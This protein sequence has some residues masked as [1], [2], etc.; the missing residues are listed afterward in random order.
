MNRIAFRLIFAVAAALGVITPVAAYVL[1][2]GPYWPD[3]TVTLHLKLGDSPTYTDSSTP[4]STAAEAAKTW[5]PYIGRVQLATTVDGTGAGGSKNGTNEVFFSTSAYGQ[6]F[7]TDVLAVTLIWSSSTRRTE[8]D[9]IVNASERWDSYRGSLQYSATDLRRVLVH[10]F[11]HVLGLDHP[12]QAGQSVYSIMNA[13]IGNIETPT[14]DDQ[15]GVASIYGYG[16]GNQPTPPHISANTPVDQSIYLGQPVT[17]SVSLGSSDTPPFTYQW[18][19]NDVAIIGAT[20]DSY[21][22][23]QVQAS[24]AGTYSVVVSNT[25]GS[26]TSREA[27]LTVS[28]APPPSEGT[29]TAYGTQLSLYVP[30][31]SLTPTYGYQWYRDGQAIA[32]ATSTYYNV[33]PNWANTPADYLAVVTNSRGSVA[34]QAYS[35]VPTL[36]RN[37]VATSSWIAVER[38]GDL[39]YFLC[40]SPARIERYDIAQDKWL[41]PISLGSTPTAFRTDEAGLFV[42][43]GSSVMR[44]DEAGVVGTTLLSGLPNNVKE[45]FVASGILYVF[46]PNEAT[47]SQFKSVRLSDGLVVDTNSSLYGI[48]RVGSL[49]IAPK[50]GRIFGRDFALSP[51]DIHALTFKPDGTLSPQVDSPYHG[52]YPDATRTFVSPD[53]SVVVDDSGTIYHT[54]DLTFAGSYG[55]A[56]DDIAFLDDG[57]AVVLRAATLTLYDAN[58]AEIGRYT[59]TAAASRVYVDGQVVVALAQPT[60]TGAAAVVTRLPLSQIVTRPAWPTVASAGHAYTPTDVSVGSDNVVYLLDRLSGAIHRWSIA[61]GQYLDPV[62]LTGNPNYMTYLPKANALCVAYGDLRI[63]KIDVANSTAELPFA[64]AETVIGGL[65]SVGPY[66]FASDTLAYYTYDTAGHAVAWNRAYETSKAYAWNAPKQRIYHFR[67]NISPNDLLYKGINSDGSFGSGMPA[68]YDTAFN[69]ATPIVISTDGTTVL[70]GTGTLFDADAM[71]QIKTLPNPIATGVWLGSKLYTAR[72]T[73]DGVK[74]ERWGGSGFALDGTGLVAGQVVKLLATADNYLLLVVLRDQV[75]AFVLLDADLNDLTTAPPRIVSQPQAITAVQGTPVTLSTQAT[76]IGLT[77]QWT[78]DGVDLPGATSATLD[79]GLLTS[80]SAGTYT[81]TAH[82]SVGGTTSTAVRVGLTDFAFAGTY[83][84]SFAAGGGEFSLVVRQDGSNVLLARLAGTNQ[85]IVATGLQIAAD[86]TFT[87]GVPPNAIVAASDPAR[88][89]TGQVTGNISGGAL[90]LTIPALALTGATA[91]A[92]GDNSTANRAGLYQALPMLRSAGEVYLAVGESGQAF[93]LELGSGAVRTGSG[94]LV[95]GAL[96][97]TLG[98]GPSATTYALTL[99]G[100]GLHATATTG[101]AQVTLEPAP[102]MS[103]LQRLANISSRGMAGSGDNTLIAGFVIT[104]NEA[105]DVLIRAVGPTLATMQVSGVLADPRL[106]LYQGSTPI[107]QNDDWGAAAGDVVGTAARVGAFVLTPGSHD[108]AVVAHLAPG[109]YTTHVSMPAGTSGVA[110]IEVYDAGSFDKLAPRAVNIS[111]RAHVG[112]G[113]NVL[114][115]GFVIDGNAPK[116]ILVRGVGPLLA[117]QGVN[118]VLADP[119]IKLFHGSSVIASNDNWGDGSDAALIASA[120]AKVG[121][122][123]LAAGSKDASL[124]LYLDPGIYTVIVDGVG[125]TTGVAMV[126]VYEVTN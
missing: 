70:L 109:L 47:Y 58:R 65:C 125:Q 68:P 53:Q 25:V 42:A 56:F 90:T 59:L 76:G 99:G 31:T 120:A 12:D 71:T 79:L 94:V 30:Y 61:S 2:G 82:N 126:E 110:M 81:V 57:Q 5:N 7:G 21:V 100:D 108:A 122:V 38:R 35:Y 40:T 24:D 22:I 17:F 104:G 32:G 89:Y 41:A 77:Y 83:T 91:K 18:R 27:T 85:A 1:E 37:S 67:D 9:V 44:F 49:S 114:I 16:I 113:D 66:V 45:L 19:K 64:S 98:T 87:F 29:I 55:G 14:A 8:T 51:T 117:A 121:A 39:V 23:P 80:A 101:S 20:S 123:S 103:G 88:W 72:D 78:K 124:L 4:N 69:V 60:G 33:P 95:A 111:T 112:T 86:G 62:P 11:G 97:L 75:P 52:D 84:G 74:V 92:A 48:S 46:Y 3:G 26:A 34:S 10:E 119:E 13:Y 15:S 118:G 96:Q 93:L 116:K 43:F 6:S 63:T 28:V 115:A 106:T 105:K 50:V 54:T 102:A 107:M 36:T 73:L